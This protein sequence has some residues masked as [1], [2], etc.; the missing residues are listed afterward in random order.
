MMWSAMTNRAVKNP[1]IL[2]IL[3]SSSSGPLRAVGRSPF[4]GKKQKKLSDDPQ[5]IKK[6]IQQTYIVQEEKKKIIKKN[7]Q[8][9][10]KELSYS[11]R[12]V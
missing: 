1:L 10:A 3:L 11:S 5:P 9:A 2:F 8:G 6:E 4:P 7:R 12:N